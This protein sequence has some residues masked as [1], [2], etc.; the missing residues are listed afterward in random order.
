MVFSPWTMTLGQ[1]DLIKLTWIEY[2]LLPAT[3][4]IGNSKVSCCWGITKLTCILVSI[5]TVMEHHQVS[6]YE[7]GLWA[8]ESWPWGSDLSTCNTWF[9]WAA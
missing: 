3:D 8:C 7:S 4:C 5:R 2:Y 9:R 1:T 6:G